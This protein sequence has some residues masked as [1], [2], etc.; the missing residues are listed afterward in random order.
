MNIIGLPNLNNSCFINSAVQ[1]LLYN[2]ELHN[3]LENHLNKHDLIKYF[4]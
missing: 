2:E 1:S 4:F 3:A